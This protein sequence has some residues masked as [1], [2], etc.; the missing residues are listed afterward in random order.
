MRNHDGREQE[1][2]ARL[3]EWLADQ[4][5]EEI[6]DSSSSFTKRWIDPPFPLAC[7]IHLNV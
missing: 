7:L 2:H 1:A 4:W 6:Q 3:I 5:W